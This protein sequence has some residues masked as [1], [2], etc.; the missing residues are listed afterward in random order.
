MPSS[1]Y[2]VN[3]AADF[4]TYFGAEALAASGL[5]PAVMMADLAA[6]TVAAMAPSD[7]DVS[8]C[9]ETVSPV[10]F[11][12][13]AEWI[14]LT[15]K[16]SQRQRMIAIADEFRRRGKRV[17]IGGPYASLSPARVRDHCDVMVCGE[18]EEI[19]GEL[20]SDLRAGRPRDSYFG[21]KPDL[22]LTPPPRWELY[23]NDR[24]LLGAV[25]TSRGCP[26]ECEFCD[27]I[28]YLGRKQRHKPVANVLAEI[29]DLYRRG[30]RA[31]FLAD[32][33]FTA[34]R[35]RCKELLEAIAWW[36]RDHPM[37][38]VTQI[39]ID[40]TRDE[41]LLDMCSA[42]GLTQ[43]FIGIETPN[44]ESLRETG[45]RQNLRVDLA[46]EVQ[47]LVDRGISVMGGMI[48]GFDADGPSVFAQQYEF[49]MST[50][51]PMFSLGALMAS[52]ATPLYDRIIREGRLVPGDPGVQAVPWSSNIEPRTMSM[53]ELNAGLQ[54]L[55]NALYAPEAF[56][57]RMLRFIETFGRARPDAPP[58]QMDPA[59]LRFIDR[60]AF[61]LAMD[62][63]RMGEKEGRMWNRV[64]GAAIRRP[65]TIAIVSRI[66]F[67]YA[68]A[69][70][71]FAQGSYWEPQLAQPP[72]A[73]SPKA[74]ALSA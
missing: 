63:R 3:P 42:A 62:V 13:P 24:A 40:A 52:E 65:A 23:P 46:A 44:V 27:V 33:N 49:A 6:A 14:A 8:I 69:R 22:S 48:V 32:D 26:F 58:A 10:D 2:I 70:H 5:S 7:F 17:I 54:N 30:Y 19:A 53:E 12:H 15:G 4:P 18:A 11:D 73:P 72:V 34:Y 47:K 36:R 35:S 9:D 59:S 31:V 20:F 51:V 55:C 29:D 57:E 39:S 60:Q 25:Q 45:K 41:E 67:Q 21:D 56:G 64:W 1:L 38:F 50:S 28:Q 74:E 43:V 71:M 16:V 37:E 66:L 61:Q 68:Q